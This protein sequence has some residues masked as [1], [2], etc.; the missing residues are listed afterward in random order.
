M[1]IFGRMKRAAKSKANAAI[2]KMIDPARELEM[3]ILDLEAQQANARKELLAYKTTAKQMEQDIAALEE[4]GKHWE[5]RAM[6]AVRKGDDALAKQCLVEQKNCATQAAAAKRDRDEAAGYAVELNRSRKK[7]ETQLQILKLKKGT[8]ATQ[9]AAARS[10]TGNAFGFTNEAFDKLDRAEEKIDS[11]AAMAEAEAA[12]EGDALGT[13]FD[14]KLLAAGA[15]PK[16]DV[17]A[18][19][20]LARLKAKVAEDRER[21][22]LKK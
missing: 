21:K 14:A 19:T 12:M 7:V 16:G 4:K 1:G 13:E 8:M 18:D 15:D 17:G 3:A 2:D 11:E 5:Q 9:I 10:G 6:Q 20:E 22:Q